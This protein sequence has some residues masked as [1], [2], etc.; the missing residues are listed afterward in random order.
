MMAQGYHLGAPSQEAEQIDAQMAE[1]HP[2][3]ACGGPMHYEGFHRE[4]NGR[5]EYIALAV[6]NSCG[7]E[8]AF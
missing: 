2:C 8:V 6:C 4:E 3:P 7:K 1:R 5:Q